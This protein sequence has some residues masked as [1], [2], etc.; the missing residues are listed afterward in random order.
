VLQTQASSA[1]AQDVTIHP[2]ISATPVLGDTRLIKRLVANL[3]DNAVRYNVSGG[4]VDITV[5]NANGRPTLRIANTGP[6][7]PAD[8]VQRLLQPFQ[9]QHAPR[10]GEHNGL[11]LGLSIVAPSLTHTTPPSA[12][13]HNPTAASTST[14]ASQRR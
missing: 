1:I 14:S 2:A 4:R 9:R 11:G 12:Y 5:S 10:R 8:Q 7:I 6:H 13:N 3:M